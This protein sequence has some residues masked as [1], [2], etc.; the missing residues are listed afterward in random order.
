MRKNGNSRMFEGNTWVWTETAEGGR[1][2]ER[3]NAVEHEGGASDTRRA[4]INSY[5]PVGENPA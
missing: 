5:S 1:S 2:A 4:E 3:E